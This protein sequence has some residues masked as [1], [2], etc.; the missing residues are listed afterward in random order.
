M[1]CK[2]HPYSLQRTRSPPGPSFPKRVRNT[3]PRNYFEHKGKDIDLHFSFLSWGIIL[4]IELPRPENPANTYA[5]HTDTLDSCFD[6]I[7]SVYRH[8]HHWRSNQQSQFVVPK[9]QLSHQFISHT[10]DAK[11]TSHGRF[12][13]RVIELFFLTKDD[14][15]I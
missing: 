9:L 13:L 10:S 11:L 5:W 12:F 3:H 8:P 14:R 4:W 1:S 2:L 7:N 6:L 15:W